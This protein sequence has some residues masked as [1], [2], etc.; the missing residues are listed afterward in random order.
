MG[1]DYK[2]QV[3]A[4]KASTPHSKNNEDDN[5]LQLP[6][7]PKRF[8]HACP[9]DRWWIPRQAKERRQHRKSHGVASFHELAR[10]IS[11]SWKT[12]QTSDQETHEWCCQ[13][14]K[15]RYTLIFCSNATFLRLVENLNV[16]L[17]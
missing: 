10:D 1:E 7:L 6:P 2:A 16:P 13:V 4:K 17:L 11:H 8:A 5:E 12:L 15:V 3:A 14:E 9:E